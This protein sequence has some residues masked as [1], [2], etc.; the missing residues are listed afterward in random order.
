MYDESA[1]SKLDQS[2][3]DRIE[4]MFSG[5]QEVIGVDHVASV[6]DGG[7]SHSGDG[8]LVAYICLLYTSPSPRD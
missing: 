2:S 7:P 1:L 4:R 8:Q 5:C 3:R 6:L